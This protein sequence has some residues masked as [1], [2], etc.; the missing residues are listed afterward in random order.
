ML[1]SGVKTQDFG[2]YKVLISV[3]DGFAFCSGAKTEQTYSRMYTYSTSLSTCRYFVLN[4]AR[5]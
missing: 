4:E 2:N 3:V 1:V 5:I